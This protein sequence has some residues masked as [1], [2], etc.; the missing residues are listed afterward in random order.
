MNKKK[1]TILCSIFVLVIIG[2]V[3]TSYALFTYNVTKN[4]PF[5]VAVGNLQLS[6]SDN[7][8][9]DKII[10]ND[11]VPTKDEVALS[12]S[13]YNF[14]ITNTGS[15]DA[16]FILYL[17]NITPSN[18]SKER[19]PDN[20]VKINLTNTTT[21]QSTTYTLSN[22]PQKVIDT[23]T[24]ASNASN[25]YTLRVWL[26]YSAGNEAQNK[27]YAGKLRIEGTQANEREY[28]YIDPVLNGTDPVLT[29]N[30]VPVKLDSDG[31]VHKADTT[32]EW[33]NYTNKEWANAVVTRNSYETL[34]AYG[35]VNGATLNNDGYV[36][37]D[38]VD[39]YIDLGL[40]NYDFGNSIT[41]VIK[42]KFNELNK[43]QAFFG[44]FENSGIGLD[45]LSTN[46]VAALMKVGNSWVTVSSNNAI[47]LDKV[48]TI[49]LVYENSNLKL[50]SL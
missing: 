20:L 13:G 29:S 12:Q 31:T 19:L 22:L 37:F 26:D 23:G 38:G 1:I 3:A 9:Q 47:T 21:N 8:N 50:F 43:E 41:M 17:D 18:N 32:K 48:Y 6:I 39:D 14:T 35:K 30:L 45:L 2:A 16:N 36:S 11:M 24:L 25:S 46:Y 27:Y 33:Y 5:K 42:V 4:S 28:A 34:N 15:I 49:I 10:I 40:T 44:N 7:V